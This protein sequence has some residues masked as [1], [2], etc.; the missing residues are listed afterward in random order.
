MAFGGNWKFEIGSPL[1]KQK[2]TFDL[3]VEGGKV[4][5]TM[6]SALGRIAIDGTAD[7]DHATWSGS[8]TAPMSMTL[9]F[10]VT[11]DGDTMVGTAETGAMGSFS[12]KATRT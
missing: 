3:V 4:T 1:G 5:G 10:D 7:G 11:V 9:D 12:V 8:V 2:G 6:V